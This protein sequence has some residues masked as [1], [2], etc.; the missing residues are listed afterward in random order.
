MIRNSTVSDSPKPEA[1]FGAR[2]VRKQ[3][4]LAHRSGQYQELIRQLFA[5][6]SVVAIVSSGSS[7]GSPAICEGIARE[8]AASGRLVVVVPVNT[9]LVMNTIVPDET[10][11]SPGRAPH[12]WVWPSPGGQHIEFFK[13]DRADNWLDALRRNFDAVL[14]DCPAVDT[15]PGIPEVAVMADAAVLLVQAG[16]TP[17]TEVQHAQRTLQLRGVH[18]A[19][20]I[21]I[22][23]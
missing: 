13:S 5:E 6:S 7:Q 15:M 4:E 1:V 16:R 14:L 11:F 9:V 20:S 12:V 23:R 19:G 10:A 21:L 2:A 22:R 18:V 8:L 3:Q 17:K